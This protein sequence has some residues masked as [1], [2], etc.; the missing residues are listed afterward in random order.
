MATLT[1]LRLHQPSVVERAKIETLSR[2]TLVVVVLTVGMKYIPVV[3]TAT[4][5]VE[6][7]R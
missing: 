6:I 1:G 3:S 4:L 7:V 5:A 2:P